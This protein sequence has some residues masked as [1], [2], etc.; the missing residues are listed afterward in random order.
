MILKL[1]KK[2]S[3]NLSRSFMIGDRASDIKCGILAGCK[4]IFINRN[5]SEK[6]PNNQDFTVESMNKAVLI[7]KNNS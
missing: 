7:I 2:Y 3:I 5:Y 1:T 6:K 4:T